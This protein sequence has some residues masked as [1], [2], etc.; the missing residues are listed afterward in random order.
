[1]GKKQESEGI[2]KLVYSVFYKG[3]PLLTT[4]V[5]FVFVEYLMILVIF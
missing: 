4:P 1:M 3:N 5:I 2:A